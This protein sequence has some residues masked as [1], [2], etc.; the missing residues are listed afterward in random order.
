VRP[1]PGVT[2]DRLIRQVQRGVLTATTIVR[3][4]T[5]YHQWRYAAETPGLSKHLE[6]CWNC[7]AKVS[8]DDT[9]CS[10]CKVN[11]D[12]PPGLDL[13]A[14]A[15]TNTGQP[16]PAVATAPPPPPPPKKSSATPAPVAAPARSAA[17]TPFAP[18]P[19]ARRPQYGANDIERIR[20]ALGASPEKSLDPPAR[21]V[22]VAVI[23][24][25][26]VVLA[27]VALFAVVQLRGHKQPPNAN[28]AT[29]EVTLPGLNTRETAPTQPATQVDTTPIPPGA[30]A[31][32][33]PHSAQSDAAPTNT[34][35]TN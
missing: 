12:H 1:F 28:P 16:P 13:E 22:P 19:V 14:D 20:A 18:S 30:N 21:R 33:P 6:L 11:L 29:T 5:T 32:S 4:P 27:I 17:S 15:P 2:L 34:P 7:Q 10:A 9:V 24:A 31:A 25:V 3:G 23:I 26:I 8:P 35:P